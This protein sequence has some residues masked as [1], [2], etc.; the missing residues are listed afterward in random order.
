M[1]KW[2]AFIRNLNICKFYA[3]IDTIQFV[4]MPESSDGWLLILLN[5]GTINIIENDSR[6]LFHQEAKSC[7]YKT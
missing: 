6:Q 7:N 5:T 4:N 1:N 2:E 3:F